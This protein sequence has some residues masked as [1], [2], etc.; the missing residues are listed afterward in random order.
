MVAFGFNPTHRVL[1]QGRNILVQEIEPGEYATLQDVKEFYPKPC[2]LGSYGIGDYEG[3][4]KRVDTPLG[5]GEYQV[6]WKQI[7]AE[8]IP[9]CPTCDGITHKNGYGSTGKQRYKCK[10][11]F[12]VFIPGAKKRGNN[13]WIDPE[14]LER[15]K[16]AA[17]GQELSNYLGEMFAHDNRN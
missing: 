3:A 13:C 11:C 14:V 2:G 8:I 4:L 1:F 16:D 7:D 10:K 12:K 5:G 6:S 15:I 17:E 9:I